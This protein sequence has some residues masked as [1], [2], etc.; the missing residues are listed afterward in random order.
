MSKKV[1]TFLLPLVYFDSLF[2][3]F[4]AMKAGKEI[5]Q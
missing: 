3:D 2:V 4:Q 1:K 5:N